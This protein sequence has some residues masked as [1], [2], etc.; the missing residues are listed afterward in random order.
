MSI[1]LI[2]TCYQFITVN[3]Y[4]LASVASLDHYAPLAT[5]SIPPSSGEIM[6]AEIYGWGMDMIQHWQEPEPKDM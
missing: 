1:T 2:Q 6:Q 4:R 5:T 3:H